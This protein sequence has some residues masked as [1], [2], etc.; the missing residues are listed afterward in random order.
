MLI[1]LNAIPVNSAAAR[2]PDM[3]KVY[4]TSEK[5]YF[6]FALRNATC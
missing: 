3:G 4:F 5:I 1:A 6:Q 2:T